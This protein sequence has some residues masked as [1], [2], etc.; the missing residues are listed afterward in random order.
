MRREHLIKHHLVRV[1]L[2]DKIDYTIPASATYGK[3][4]EAIEYPEPLPANGD[5][6][7]APKS[8]INYRGTLVANSNAP[9]VLTFESS[10]ERNA[11]LILQT[12]RDIVELLTQQPTCHF[13]DVYGIRHAHTFDFCARLRNGKRLGIAAKPIMKLIE[14][15]LVGTLLR[16]KQ[17]G[18]NGL[19]DDVNFVTETFASDDAAHNAREILLSRRLRNEEEYQAALEVVKGV[20]GPVTFRALFVGAEVPAHRRTALWCLIDEGLLRPAAPGRIEDTTL[21]IVTL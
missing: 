2:G 1:R 9:R 15:N 17:Q 14:T 21:M 10:V 20:R 19:L 16:I 11:A 13:T 12:N 3:P 5:R 8:P 4:T 7:P 18:M 6:T